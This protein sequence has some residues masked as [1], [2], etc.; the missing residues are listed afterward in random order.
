MDK[1]TAVLLQQF[2]EDNINENSKLIDVYKSI[3][4]NNYH[5]DYIVQQLKSVLDYSYD[6]DFLSK[7]AELI[8]VNRRDIRKL[9]DVFADLLGNKI[10]QMCNEDYIF[11]KPTK[12]EDYCAFPRAEIV[13]YTNRPADL[14]IIRHDGDV[15]K[16]LS[17]K[18]EASPYYEIKC[19]ELEKM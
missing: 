10:E 4:N 16:I 14:E 12:F 6:F 2:V 3:M 17:H 5:F 9:L 18:L 8:E 15:Y 11:T 1:S 7:E 13:L 19:Y